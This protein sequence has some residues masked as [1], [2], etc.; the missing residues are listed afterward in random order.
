MVVSA[1]RKHPWG[2]CGSILRTGA[3]RPWSLPGKAHPAPEQ[4]APPP[5]VKPFMKPARRGADRLFPRRPHRFRRPHPGPPGHPFPAPGVA[6]TAPDS[7][8][9]RPSPIKSWPAGWA[10]PRPPGPWARPMRLIPS[11]S[12]SPAT[13]SFNADGGLGGY[14]SGLDRKR[15][16]L[17]HEGAR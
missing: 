9:A 7:L 2:R 10:A 17:R 8:G 14:S 5:H 1:S 11:P 15:W 3:S 13:G 16:L 12:S 6:G 4:D